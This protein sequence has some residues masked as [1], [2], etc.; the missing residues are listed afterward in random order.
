MEEIKNNW[1]NILLG[2]I[3]IYGIY[4]LG[5]ILQEYM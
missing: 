5:A 4:C 2:T 1:A 3:G